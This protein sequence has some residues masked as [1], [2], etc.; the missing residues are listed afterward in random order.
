MTGFGATLTQGGARFRVYAPDAASV[1][2]CLFQDGAER[3]LP[4]ERQG[5]G[6]WSTDVSG[7]GVGQAYGYRA[8][9]RY[10][11]KN[12]LWFDPAKVLMDPFA[13]RID[14]A[15]VYDTR[16]GLPPGEAV[17]TAPL[18]PKALVTLPAPAAAPPRLYQT[19]GLIYEANVRALTMLHP[20]V[21]EEI[22]GTLAAVAHPAVVAHLVALGVAAIEFLPITAWIDERHLGP[23]GLTNAWGY[24]PV[25]LMALDPRLAPGGIA[26]LRHVTDTLREAGIGVILDLVFNHTGESD[27]QGPT[28]SLRGLCNRQAY[29]H[30]HDG[31]LVNDTGTGNTLDCAHPYVT[32]LVVDALR[33]FVLA[34]GVDGFR[35]DL[36]PVLG[37]FDDGFSPDAP[38]LVAMREDPVL[39]DRVLIAEP[40]DIGPGGYQL[41]NF[42]PPFLEWNDRFRDTLRRFG[43]G[44][45]S[46][47][48]GLATVLAGSSDIF[49]GESRSVN[50]IAAHDG[51]TLADLVSYETRHNEANGEGNRDGH[52]ENLSWNNGVEGATDDPGVIAARRRDAKAL[53]ALVLLAKGTPMITAGDEFG[54]T[55]HGNNNA[56]CQ[57]GPD[58]WLDWQGGDGELLDHTRALG[59]LRAAHPVLRDPALWSDGAVDWLRPDGAPMEV[60]DWENPE[61]RALALVLPRDGPRLALLLNFTTDEIAFDLPGAWKPVMGGLTIPPR[62]VHVVAEAKP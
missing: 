52:G 3:T 12:G 10:D 61:N 58:Y 17:D 29:R 20:D 28:L 30:V 27:A 40:W 35:F 18:M 42:P 34:G 50:F 53:L 24:N 46:M 36:A 56:Y 4:M 22:R 47:I 8:N 13:T 1:L 60:S 39:A 45:R 33:H 2:L 43:R 26:D 48:G 55:Q 62:A 14:R 6:V 32:A 41:G 15:F 16:L 44:D 5:G 25:T 54:R 51:F 21:P 19:G 23:L 38:L 7:V 49:E 31:R 11:P 59:Q 57:D 9:G 37:R